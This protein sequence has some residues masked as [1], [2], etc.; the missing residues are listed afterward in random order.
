MAVRVLVWVCGRRLLGKQSETG[1]PA[2]GHVT[3]RE[4]MGLPACGR[5][6]RDGREGEMDGDEFDR[7]TSEKYYRLYITRHW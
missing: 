6:T 2:S 7:I 5:L 3:Q 1:E 4:H